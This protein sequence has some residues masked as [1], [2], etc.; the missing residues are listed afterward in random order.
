MLVEVRCFSPSL[1]S[2][3]LVLLCA[4]TQTGACTRFNP[5]R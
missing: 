1:L 3:V 5:I 2:R 4:T